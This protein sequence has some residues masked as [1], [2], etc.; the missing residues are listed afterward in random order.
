MIDEPLAELGYFAGALRE[1]GIVSGIDRAFVA[2]QA[3]AVMGQAGDTDPYWPL[4]VAFCA[5]SADVPIFDAVYR[6]WFGAGEVPEAVD[7][8]EG[9]A[10]EPGE[11]VGPQGA[12]GEGAR[13]GDA[14]ELA[15]RDIERLSDDELEQIK[16]W[17]DLLAPAPRRRKAMRRQR[18]RTGRVDVTRTMRLLLVNHGELS[19][20]RR[21]QRVHRPRRLLLLVDVSGSMAPYSDVLL[22]FAHAA[23]VAGPRT[24]EVFAVGT[25][26][27]RLTES[28]RIA[29]PA[30]AM[31]SMAAVETDWHGGTTLGRALQEFL[32]TWG[33]RNTVRAAVVVLGSDGFEFAD[34]TLLRQQTA[35]LSRLAA[36]LI[37]IDPLRRAD[38]YV[39]LDR[40]LADA[41]SYATV[42]L[43]GHNFEA[44]RELAK[45][46]GR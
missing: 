43:A 10:A 12:A 31:S 38:D 14:A 41:Q 37:W 30:V 34:Q 11:A 23:L 35:R 32:R 40:D 16:A 17:V 27:T 8:C 20:I 5:C 1:A 24:T 39:P 26:W 42:R 25:R 18:A 28:L 2:A 19:E 6:G 29:D 9:A 44:L 22:R 15:L 3:L 45:V 21:R 7:V 4:R 36:E 46:I 13:A 33:G